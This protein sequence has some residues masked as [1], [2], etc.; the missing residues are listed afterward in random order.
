MESGRHEWRLIAPPATGS[1]APELDESQLDV[2]AWDTGPAIVYAGPGTGKTTT[3]NLLAG[4]IEPDEGEIR[5]GERVV[6]DLTPDKRDVAMVG[7]DA[8]SDVMP[9]RVEGVRQ[10]IHQ[11]LLVAMG[12]PMLDQCDLE[13][14][15]RTAA[16]R[17]QWTFLL[18]VAPI[19][20]AGGTGAP[21]NPIAVF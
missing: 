21:V 13:E 9:S 2:T 11:L 14:L 17:K 20:A 4:L 1:A 6:N 5:I 15:A 7:S 18:T 16:A 8:A 10:P 3:L 12:T 19:R